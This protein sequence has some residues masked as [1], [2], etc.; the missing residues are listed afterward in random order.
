M[1]FNFHQLNFRSTWLPEMQEQGLV[2]SQDPLGVQVGVV[3][4]S[5]YEK[6]ALFTVF[7]SIDV[8]AYQ[9][10]YTK[11]IKQINKKTFIRGK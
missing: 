4:D 8:K 10:T 5:D 2:V 3:Q 7:C 6:S 9:L 1:Q 11:E